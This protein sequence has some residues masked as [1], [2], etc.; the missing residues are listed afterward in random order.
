MEE[1][2]IRIVDLWKIYEVDGS[3]VQAL[4]GTH[5]EIKKKKGSPF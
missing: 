4:R 2:I 1:P 5:L 3:E